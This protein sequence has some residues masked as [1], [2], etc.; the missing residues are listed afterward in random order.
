[1]SQSNQMKRGSSNRSIRE[2]LPARRGA[3]NGALHHLVARTEYL[4]AGRVAYAVGLACVL[5]ASIARG[6]PG[7]AI[8]QG[9]VTANA[10]YVRSGPSTNHYTICKLNAGD[11]VTLLSR[12]GEWYEILPPPGSFSLISGEYVDEGGGKDGVVNGNNVRVR[13]G[14]SLNKNKYTVQ[15]MLSKGAQV[16]ILGAEPDGFLRI[17]PPPGATLWISAQ[18]VEP[19]PDE[20]LQLQS[21]TDSAVPIA[22]SSEADV[23]PSTGALEAGDKPVETTDAPADETARSP[24]AALPV[25]EQRRQLEQLDEDTRQELAKPV[26]QRRFTQLLERYQAIAEQKE[27]RI[28]ARYAQL[29]CKEINR[30]M[31]L[32]DSVK[33]LRELDAQTEAKRRDFL[34]MRMRLP[35]LTLPLPD[36]LDVQGELR[37]SVLYPP[38]R[39]PQRYRLIDPDDPSGRTLGYVEIPSDS[40]IDVKAYL[41][42]YV[43]VRALGTRLQTGG[44]DPIPI[45]V[46]SELVLVA[47]ERSVTADS[48]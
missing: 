1:M 45:Y 18:F 4:L 6:Q 46:A 8:G 11:R 17:T 23:A 26:T 32:A 35:R 20:L 36:G 31:G 5:A 30:M 19:V 14:S 37:E 39:D 28:A 7:P 15:T 47:P 48:P 21:Q 2:S 42:R 29:R 27:D 38:E 43:G 3:D 40:T 44:V 25:S 33:R 16:E 10:V 41:G 34:S 9:E 24:F 22:A 12:R 13:A